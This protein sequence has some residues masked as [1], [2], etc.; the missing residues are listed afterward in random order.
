MSHALVRLV[1]RRTAAGMQKP[2]TSRIS[3]WHVR[4][5]HSTAPDPN[6]DPELSAIIK[7]SHE[8]QLKYSEFTQKQVDRIFFEAAIAGNAARLPLAELAVLETNKG[9]VEDKVIKNHFATEAVY[10]RFQSV[11]SCGV[12]SD[13]NTTGAS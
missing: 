10:N 5:S 1:S 2:T 8:A 7:R 3:F 9:V 11:K 12:I 13:E 6:R 4:C